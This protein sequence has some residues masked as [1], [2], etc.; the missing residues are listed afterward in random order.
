ML[1]SKETNHDN[2]SWEISKENVQPL[3]S[4]RCAASLKAALQPSTE[5]SQCLQKERRKF[6][7]EIL[8][9]ENSADPIGPWDRYLKWTQQNYPIGENKIT[10][11]NILRKFVSKFI[12]H[13]EYKN[14]PRYI[15]AWIMLAELSTDPE[16]IFSYMKSEGFGVQCSL[17]YI[18]WAD[19]LEKY[20]N[21]KKASLIYQLGEDNNAEPLSLLLKMK[22]AFEMRS[23]RES[24]K[25][26]NTEKSSPPNARKALKSL[27]ETIRVPLAGS[28]AQHAKTSNAQTS[29]T[30]FQDEESPITIQDGKWADLPDHVTAN[31]E[32]NLLRPS[33]WQNPH[34]NRSSRMPRPRVSSTSTTTSFEIFDDSSSSTDPVCPPSARK[35][36]KTVER[37]LSESKHH[38]HNESIQQML[39]ETADDKDIKV[40]RQYPVEKVYSALGEF[41]L[42]EIIA[43]ERRKCVRQHS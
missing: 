26:F 37:F 43:L 41:Q 23:A 21:I 25:S 12:K 9:G 15:K 8:A 33:T 11:E 13:A 32:N 30:I 42:E 16:N 14:D 1:T 3:R 18:A 40:V 35:V 38:L 17:F 5:H 31:K 22:H 28:K 29:L 6:E 34:K 39:F 10:F 2:E 7:E 4:G 27:S 36:S 24:F 20:G 19:E